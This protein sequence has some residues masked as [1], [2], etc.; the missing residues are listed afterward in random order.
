MVSGAPL[1]RPALGV[2]SLLHRIVPCRSGSCESS[3]IEARVAVHARYQ[4]GMYTCTVSRDR[5]GLV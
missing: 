5:V 2:G 1:G 4:V 3:E